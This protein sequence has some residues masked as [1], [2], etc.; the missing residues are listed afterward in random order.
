[1]CGKTE[2]IAIQSGKNEEEWDERNL[3][4][5]SNRTLRHAQNSIRN[6]SQTVI[7]MHAL[8]EIEMNMTPL[9]IIRWLKYEENKWTEALPNPK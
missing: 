1:M 4:E 9:L 2:N 7:S 8:K 5:N 3:I 6:E